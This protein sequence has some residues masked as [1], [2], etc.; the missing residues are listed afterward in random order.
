MTLKVIGAGYPRTGTASLKAALELLG[1]GRCYHMVELLGRPG[2]WPLWTQALE[3]KPMDFD[4]I[5]RDYAATTDAPGCFFYRALG[6]KYPAAKIILSIREGDGWFRSTQETILS[7]DVSRRF[8]AAPPEFNTLM[9]KMGWHPDDPATHDRNA[10][11]AR[12]TAHNEEVTASM[13]RGRLLIF[14]PAQGWAPLCGFLGLP[15]PD[16]PF[17]HV[18]RTQDFQTM[19]HSVD[20]LTPS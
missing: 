14:E 16:V 10:M 17:P 5:L 20:R 3:G 12:M 18:N 4:E 9:R 19:I 2:D 1:V 6:A 13:P 11:V 7:A 15:V 8:A